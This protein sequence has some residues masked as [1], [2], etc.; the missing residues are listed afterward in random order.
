MT[1]NRYAPHVY[2][3]PEDD[4]DRQIADGFVLHDQVRTQ[5]IQVMPPPG[6]WREVLKTFQAEYVRRL[7]EDL[8]GHVVMLIDFDGDYN[9]R[10]IEFKTAIPADLSER[11]FVIGA[12]QTPEDLKR[13]IGKSL[14]DIG[15]LLANDC[16]A[17][18]EIVWTHEHLRHNDPD[19]HRLINVVKPILFASPG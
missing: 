9:N 6:G 16:Y 7:R 3:I 10:F 17:G 2:V 11:V 19:R 5:R 12:K 4:R 18:T 15:T 14:E 13:E 1:M 8:Q